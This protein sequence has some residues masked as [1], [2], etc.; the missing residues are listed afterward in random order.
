MVKRPG[1]YGGYAR[2][3]PEELP[4]GEWAVLGL[5]AEGPSHG[6]AVARALAPDGDVGR[7]WSLR[8]PL[9]YR[10][11]DVLRRLGLVAPVGTEDSDAGPQRVMVE[12][13]ATGARRLDAWLAQP[14]EHVR[15]TR[16]QLMLKLL[17]LDRRGDDPRRL[18][19]AQ[20]LTSE[21]DRDR[22]AGQLEGEKGFA[23]TLLSWRL[24]ST[25]GAL[26][27]VDGLLAPAPPAP[28]AEA[29]PPAGSGNGVGISVAE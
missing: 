24:E 28:P 27:F 6:F 7:V 10:T 15:D 23:Q 3:R 13:T 21:G 29:Q 22:A 25:S 4:V 16:A 12:A 14:V 5:L 2:R 19:E 9:V 20:R 8:R 17:F 1:G 26:R 18:L 11:I